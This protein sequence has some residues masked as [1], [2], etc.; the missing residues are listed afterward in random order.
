MVLLPAGLI[1]QTLLRRPKTRFR[2]AGFRQL[3]LPGACNE[4]IHNCFLII[5]IIFHTQGPCLV[6]CFSLLSTT[7]Q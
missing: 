4:R 5:I 1:H 3:E 6:V 2:L 7:Y